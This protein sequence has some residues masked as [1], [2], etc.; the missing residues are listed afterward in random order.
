VNLGI[1]KIFDLIHGMD[2]YNVPMYALKS[3]G[4]HNNDQFAEVAIIREA[5][6]EKS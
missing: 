2:A 1:Y 4:L 5:L 3:A 6:K